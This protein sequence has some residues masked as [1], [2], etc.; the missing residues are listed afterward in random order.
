M[1]RKLRRQT[2]ASRRST[3]GVALVT[4]AMVLV[5]VTAY[6]ASAV[7]GHARVLT[8]PNPGGIVGTVGIDRA[9]SDNPFFRELGTN[10]RTCA[11]C[12]LPAQGWSITPAELHD[13]FERTDGLDPIF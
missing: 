6:A 10:G 5:I 12:H 9:D 7:S 3:T 1:D 13:R 11:T 8:F 2:Q 4:M